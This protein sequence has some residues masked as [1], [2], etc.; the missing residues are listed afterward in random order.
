MRT[1][2][3]LLP[4]KRD[5]CTCVLHVVKQ[6]VLDQVQTVELRV[7][8]RTCIHLHVFAEG[9]PPFLLHLPFFG[10][11]LVG[12]ETAFFCLSL[13]QSPSER[14]CTP[15]ALLTPIVTTSTD[16]PDRYIVVV[17]SVPFPRLRM[18]LIPVQHVTH[19][20]FSLYVQPRSLLKEKLIFLSF[21]FF[22]FFS[23]GDLL[24]ILPA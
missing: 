14:L 1:R 18:C 19:A 9:G 20:A 7:V 22:F 12:S 10:V 13:C 6:P 2:S 16:R 5:V 4:G 8:C 24:A 3:Y 23:S 11:R 15:L 17:N 21:F